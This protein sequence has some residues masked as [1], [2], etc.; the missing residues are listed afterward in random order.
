MTFH[1]WGTALRQRAIFMGQETRNKSQEERE[2]GMSVTFILQSF[3][4]PILWIFQILNK[5]TSI[6][7]HKILGKQCSWYNFYCIIFIARNHM[8]PTTDACLLK[9]STLSRSFDHSWTQK[10]CLQIILYVQLTEIT[11]IDSKPKESQE[12]VHRNSAVSQH[13]CTFGVEMSIIIDYWVG[14]NLKKNNIQIH[15]DIL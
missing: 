6:M 8:H 2:S 5:I 3:K 12:K 4:W 9:S 1:N 7:I 11:H 10:K 13:K 14:W 15:A